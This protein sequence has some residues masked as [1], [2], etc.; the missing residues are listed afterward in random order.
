MEDDND[1]IMKGLDMNMMSNLFKGKD[2]KMPDPLD[3]C[4]MAIKMGSAELLK[5]ALENVNILVQGA[6]LLAF[7]IE[8]AKDPVPMVEMLLAKGATLMTP[9]E[10]IPQLCETYRRTPYLFQAIKR[11][12]AKLVDFVMNKTGR[13]IDEEGVVCLSRKRRQLVTSNVLGA[14]AYYGLTPVLQAFLKDKLVTIEHPATESPDKYLTAYGKKPLPYERE[15]VGYMPLMLACASS[16]SNLETV[17][18]LLTSKADPTV[19]DANGNTLFHIAAAA[20]SSDILD[21]LVKSCDIDAFARNKAGDTAL[22]ICKK[23]KNVEGE[24]ILG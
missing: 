6:D 10:S 17:K 14:T 9:P 7:T 16:L 22:T 3:M 24:K 11:R 15:W 5:S 4:R 23:A 13:K 20:G 8:A 18:L 12:D 19:T 21:Y 1:N 2:G